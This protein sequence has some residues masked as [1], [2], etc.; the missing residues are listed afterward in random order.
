MSTEIQNT[1]CNPSAIDTIIAKAGE[2]FAKVIKLMC[3]GVA[4]PDEKD[5]KK[6]H[7]FSHEG[8]ELGTLSAADVSYAIHFVKQQ[9]RQ[10]GKMK[11]MFIERLIGG[12]MTFREEPTRPAYTFAWEGW[13]MYNGQA[14]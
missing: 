6:F 5:G 3:D 8:D 12:K 7:V 1:I 14:L 11:S 2:H 13:Y 4:F 9:G 10:V